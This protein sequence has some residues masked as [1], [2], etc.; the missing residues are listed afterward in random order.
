MRSDVLPKPTSIQDQADPDQHNGEQGKQD[1]AMLP[2]APATAPMTPTLSSS[3]IDADR[4]KALK[5][6]FETSVGVLASALEALEGI[7]AKASPALPLC[8]QS[9]SRLH[10]SLTAPTRIAIMGEYNCGKTSV[11]NLVLGEPLLPTSAIAN[12]R[13]PVHARYDAVPRVHAE[14]TTTSFEIDPEST[15]EIAATD[16]LQKL[17]INVP[18]ECLREFEL[19]DTPATRAIDEASRWAQICVW[20][21]MA[22]RAWGESERRSW[23]ALPARCRTDAILLATHTDALTN[24]REI[25][26]VRERLHS[27]AGGLF[28]EIAMVDATG[29]SSAIASSGRPGSIDDPTTTLA[30]AVALHRARRARTTDKIARRIARMTLRNLDAS[31]DGSSGLPVWEE[32][33]GR[34][35]RTLRAKPRGDAMRHEL[36]TPNALDTINRFDS[37]IAPR[38]PQ[39]PQLGM[40]LIERASRRGTFLAAEAALDDMAAI[41]HLVSQDTPAGFGK[42]GQPERMAACRALV[43]LLI[44]GN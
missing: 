41:L 37:E 8:T 23:T 35:R 33:A 20:C 29:S 15:P 30:H 14:T 44:S 24:A 9:L 22:S 18:L 5:Q 11:A 12:T 13:V 2:T 27:E 43:P 17:I 4:S 16:R 10:A 1:S 39:T 25:A 32:A 40:K 21:T 42:D 3:G 38:F 28:R 34:L 19:M 7:S 26:R 31:F 6:S 36:R